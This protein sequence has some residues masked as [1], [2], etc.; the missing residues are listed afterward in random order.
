MLYLQSGTFFRPGWTFPERFDRQWLKKQRKHVEG[1][2][3]EIGTTNDTTLENRKR[4]E[5]EFPAQVVILV[6]QIQN[7]WE[8]FQKERHSSDELKQKNGKQNLRRKMEQI[9]GF[10]PPCAARCIFIQHHPV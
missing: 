6:S 2:A 7:R 3:K 8:W 9:S 4:A 10:C 5:Q 1:A